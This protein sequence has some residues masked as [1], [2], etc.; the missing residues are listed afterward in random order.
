MEVEMKMPDLATTGGELRV[1]AWLVAVGAP[2]TRGAPLLEV[3]TEKATMEVESIATGVLKR[4]LIEPGTAVA[5]GCPIAVIETTAADGAPR[6]VDAAAK[7][8]RAETLAPSAAPAADDARPSVAAGGGLFARNR[9]RSPVQAGNRTTV[10]MS[11]AQ[12]TVARRMVASKQTAPHFYLQRSFDASRMVARRAAPGGDTLVWDAFFVVAAGRALQHYDRMRC[13]MD[14]DQL[15]ASAADAVGVAIDLDGDLFVVPIAHPAARTLEDVSAEIRAAVE[16]LRARDPELARVQTA[17]L[18]V[19]NLGGIGIDAFIP[20]INPPEAAI[21]GIGAITL[22]PAVVDGAVVARPRC[23]LTLAV[24]HRVAN[25][26]YAAVFLGEIVAQLE[27]GVESE[28][29]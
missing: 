29:P 22:Q 6:A 19:S 1:M 23:T 18:T 11:P 10:P 16:R 4:A 14:G 27:S 13:R 21:L 5:V 17:D 12:R 20:I 7:A 8:A 25:G 3:E 2:V 28:Q 24:D 26:R 15:T 9:A